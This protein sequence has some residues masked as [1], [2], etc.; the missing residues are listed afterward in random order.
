MS[1]APIAAGA[2]APSSTAS[3]NPGPASS[4]GPKT[5]VPSATAGGVAGEKGEATSKKPEKPKV[6][7]AVQNC[8]KRLENAKEGKSD[9]KMLLLCDVRITEYDV[10]QLTPVVKASTFLRS[11]SLFGSGITAAGARQLAS[12]LSSHESLTMLDLGNNALGPKGVED[13]TNALLHNSTLLNIGMASTDMQDAGATHIAH[14]LRMNA[15][16]TEVYLN[17]NS[18]TEV[19]ARELAGS[20]MYNDASRLKNLFVFGNPLGE[21]GTQE[22]VKLRQ[23]VPMA[24]ERHPLGDEMAMAFVMGTH[25]RLGEISA[26]RQLRGGSAGEPPAPHAKSG[27]SLP[28]RRSLPVH[29]APVCVLCVCVCVCVCAT[30]HFVSRTHK[31]KCF[32]RLRVRRLALRPQEDQ[33]KLEWEEG[34]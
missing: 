15:S 12:A 17:S 28:K 27:S 31:P 20:L 19:G 23:E 2:S 26:V 10:A 30:E 6:S 9:L 18:I 34:T 1:D 21:A 25:E 4:I 11:L 22:F 33:A 24:Q 32:H 13:V 3:V 16:L 7:V 14:V 5:A 29:V 8:I